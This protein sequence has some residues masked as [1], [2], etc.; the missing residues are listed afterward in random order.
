MNQPAPRPRPDGNPIPPRWRAMGWMLVSS[1]AFVGL[2]ILVRLIS[3]ELHP[4]VVVAWSNAMGLFWLLPLFL[5]STELLDPARMRVHARRAVWM[6]VAILASYYAV[7]HAPLVPVLAI[8]LA[9][10]LIALLAGIVLRREKAGPLQAT[11]LG[12]GALGVFAVVPGDGA[13]STGLWAAAL[14]AIA[15]AALQLRAHHTARDDPR[16]TVLWTFLLMVPASILLALPFWSWPREHIW[17]L[18]LGMG[19]CAAATHLSMLRAQALAPPAST[20]PFAYLRLALV[21]LAGAALF[22]EHY[23]QLTMI[24][25]VVVIFAGILLARRAPAA[26]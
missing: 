19:A 1:I 2:W 23:D 10:P 6:L 16:A 12:I 22:D 11:A 21:A 13:A 18:L 9:A 26:R 24:G 17:S 3:T 20:R 15:M 8:G 7:A 25:A 5:G 14:A 4:F